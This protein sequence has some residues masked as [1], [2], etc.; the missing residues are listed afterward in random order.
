MGQGSRVLESRGPESSHHTSPSKAMTQYPSH[1]SQVIPNS[2]ASRG[3]QKNLSF[4][5]LPCV[6]AKERSSPSGVISTPQVFIPK[7]EQVLSKRFRL[8]RHI[9]SGEL[10]RVYEAIDLTFGGMYAIKV[11]YPWIVENPHSMNVVVHSLK[12]AERLQHPGLNRCY[13]LQQDEALGLT[14]YPMEL[15]TGISL[16]FL[17][18]QR[19]NT[20]YQSTFSALEVLKTMEQIAPSLHFLHKRNQVHGNLKPTNIIFP[21]GLLGPPAKLLDFGCRL[22]NGLDSIASRN[23]A[24]SKWMYK[25]SPN[26]MYYISH[27]QRQNKDASLSAADDIFSLGVI[28]YQ[29]LTGELP[30]AMAPPPSSY[31]PELSEKLD[32]V[33]ARAMH[34]HSE[35]AFQCIHEYLSALREALSMGSV[36][37]IASGFTRVVPPPQR[38]S[39]VLPPHGSMASMS[40]I[41]SSFPRTKPPHSSGS[42]IAPSTRS[43]GHLSH[44]PEFYKVPLPNTSTFVTLE[45]N[46]SQ[47]YPSR[48]MGTAA[49]SRASSATLRSIPTNHAPQQLRGSHP[50]LQSQATHNGNPEKKR[51]CSSPRL[52]H[53][54]HPE[55]VSGFALHP[56]GTLLAAASAGN[57]KIWD[58]QRWQETETFKPG[59][60]GLQNLCWSANGRYMAFVC[61]LTTVQIWDWKKHK[62]SQALIHDQ[63][64]REIALSEDGYILCTVTTDHK[65]HVWNAAT[66]EYRVTIQEAQT[67]FTHLALEEQGHVLALGSRDG[68]IQLWDLG[69]NN[70]LFAFPT[71]DSPVHCLQFVPKTSTLLS[72]HANGEIHL[73]DFHKASLLQTFKDHKAPICSLS[74]SPHFETFASLA[75]D[76][77]LCSWSIH[78]PTPQQTLRREKEAQFVCIHSQEQWMAS[79]EKNML[80]VWDLPHTT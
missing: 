13:L 76:G 45:K 38:E 72:G 70:K 54:L 39:S 19:K 9:A 74:L 52:H 68:A 3:S 78:Q 67:P 29:M 49:P 4:T 2:N 37:A 43:M 15:A 11:L 62:Q 12:T 41:P 6:L 46:N 80:L 33:L 57:I 58:T 50:S 60:I 22:P 61:Q 17:I 55:A 40:S 71:N 31:T 36:S 66:G 56:Q 44:V 63:P 21:E 35:Q 1:A 75:K 8:L 16:A 25:A 10:G 18:E 20:N 30:V 23:I 69:R 73:W 59:E 47:T 5:E 28:T 34:S 27:Q 14:Y 65:A 77:S 26:A 42:F 64:I 48:T 53:T 51:V 24:S 32:K 7:E 79:I